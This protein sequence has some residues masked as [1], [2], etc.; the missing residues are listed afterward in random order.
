[1]KDRRA[2]TID[3]IN[4]NGFPFQIEHIAGGYAATVAWEDSNDEIRESV[5]I[6]P[7]VRAVF[8]Y[9]LEWDEERCAEIEA[10]ELRE[11]DQDA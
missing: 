4:P 7:T 11:E 10:R 2:N 9:V 6:S 8:E 3:G 1:M 5:L